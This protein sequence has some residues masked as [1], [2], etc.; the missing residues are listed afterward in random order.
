[1]TDMTVKLRRHSVNGTTRFDVFY[2]TSGN[3]G[4]AL[5]WGPM[6]RRNARHSGPRKRADSDRG[7]ACWLVCRAKDLTREVF[8][9]A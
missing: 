7:S 5:L 2:G 9:Y 8:A 1:M 6:Y 4:W 3:T